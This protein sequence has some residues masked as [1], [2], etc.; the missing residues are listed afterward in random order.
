MLLGGEVKVDRVR[1]RYHV[2]HERRSLVVLVGDRL[3]G[4]IDHRSRGGRRTGGDLLAPSSSRRRSRSCSEPGGGPESTAKLYSPLLIPVLATTPFPSEV[5]NSIRPVESGWPSS[6]IVPFT[7]TRHVAGS[8]PASANSNPTASRAAGRGGRMVMGRIGFVSV[9]AKTLACPGR[10]RG[11][12]FAGVEVVADD[13]TVRNPAESLPCRQWDAVVDEADASV[14]QG[15]VH[16]ADVAAPGGGVVLTTVARRCCSRCTGGSGSARCWC[17]CRRRP[18][19]SPR[20][21]PGWSSSA[22][23]DFEFGPVVTYRN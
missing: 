18:P 17:W 8:A 23:G 19:P 20:Q 10:R 9:G 14:A 12:S 4:L 6:F 16:P 1:S 13:L 11:V 22:S 2:L 7:G 3:N 15:D 21:K 5:R